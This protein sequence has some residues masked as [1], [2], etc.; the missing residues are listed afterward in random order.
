MSSWC[1][2]P[3]LHTRRAYICMYMFSA[4]DH[5]FIS[6]NTYQLIRVMRRSSA[7]SRGN[8]I[9]SELCS[10]S[11]AKWLR[12]VYVYSLCNTAAYDGSMQPL[13]LSVC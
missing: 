2:M 8:L 10:G 6:R 12:A 1:R 11:P 9:Y 3:Q 7:D 5:H 13:K 4:H